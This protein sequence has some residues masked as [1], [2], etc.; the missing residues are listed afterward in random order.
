MLLKSN[1]SHWSAMA[2]SRFEAFLRAL[3]ERWPHPA[4]LLITGAWAAATW[5]R[6]RH[7]RDVDFEVAGVPARWMEAFG[8]AVRAA[9]SDSG[10]M[11]QYSTRIDRWSELSLLAYRRNAKAVKRYGQLDVRVLDP[12]HWS[13]GK[14]GRYVD[15]DVADLVEVFKRV[16]PD[17]LTVARLWS[18][19]LRASPPSSQLWNIKRQMLDFFRSYGAS[20]WKT[21]VPLERIER[22]FGTPEAVRGRSRKLS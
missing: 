17:P 15:R 14:V 19:A 2:D 9:E 16:R 7:T 18:R 3:S 8:E 20:V 12:L 6:V 13:L 4:T 10:L 5:G 21:P 11:A 22:L 1:S